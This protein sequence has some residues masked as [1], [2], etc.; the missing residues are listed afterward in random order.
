[1]TAVPFENLDIAFGRGVQVDLDAALSKIVDDGRGGWCFE[2]NAAFAALVEALGFDVRLL[3]AAALLD[4]PNQTIDHLALEVNLDQPYLVD[5]GFGRGSTRPLELN[6]SR[7]QGGG[8]ADY[9]LFGSPQGTTLARLDDDVPTAL[10]RFKRVAH[11][12]DDFV[13][14]SNRL[15]AQPNSRWQQPFATRL[16]DRGPDRVTL[17][18]D[19][20]RVCRDGSAHETDVPAEQWH[21]TLEAWF[22]FRLEPDASV[23]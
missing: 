21:D 14:A 16:L 2:V 6:S 22:G 3:G 9:Q 20:L 12:L 17:T 5:V 4:G 18:A 11:R 8:D 1:M 10:Y 19:K 15:Q 23:E 7:R 13:A